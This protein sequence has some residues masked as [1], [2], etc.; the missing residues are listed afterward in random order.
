M[1]TQTLISLVAFTIAVVATVLIM[2]K[3]DKHNKAHHN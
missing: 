2:G 1:D 3:L